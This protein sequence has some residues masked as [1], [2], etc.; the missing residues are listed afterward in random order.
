MIG[1]GGRTV[2]PPPPPPPPGDVDELFSL[3]LKKDVVPISSLS[4]SDDEITVQGY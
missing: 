4:E 1:G 2:T 3:L